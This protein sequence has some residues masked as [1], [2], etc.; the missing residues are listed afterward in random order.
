[1][2]Y[3][4]RWQADDVGVVQDNDLME[5]NIDKL[6]IGLKAP[7]SIRT[8]ELKLL[9][10]EKDTTCACRGTR[11]IGDSATPQVRSNRN[12]RCLDA[13]EALVGGIVCM[14]RCMNEVNQRWTY[15]SSTGKLKYVQHQCFCLGLNPAQNKKVQLQG[16]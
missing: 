9:Q 13:F 2:T 1:M 8:A 10:L 14:Y 12:V 15:E 4:K 5:I 16:L 3:D 6:T 7:C 11:A